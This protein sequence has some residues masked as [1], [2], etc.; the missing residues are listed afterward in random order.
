MD[1]KRG[2]GSGPE[3]AG[4]RP[5]VRLTAAAIDRRLHQPARRPGL[6]D[7]EFAVRLGATIA[8]WRRR[9][10]LSREAL[11]EAVGCDRST[12]ARWEKGRRLPPLTALLLLGRTLGCGAAALLPND[13]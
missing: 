7:D 13:D 5:P 10:G 6:P 2:D 1:P 3:P 9:R 8:L 12:L 11:A 4:G